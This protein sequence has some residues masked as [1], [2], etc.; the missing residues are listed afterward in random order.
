MAHVISRRRALAGLSVAATLPLVG[1]VTSPRDADPGP[2]RHG[3]ASGDPDHHSVILWTRVSGV[4]STA[5]GRWEV[6]AGPGFTEIV[7]AGDFTTDGSRDYTVKVL[8][9]SLPAGSLLYYRFALDGLLSPTGRT[10]TNPIGAVAQLGLAVAACSNYPFGYFNAY[11]AIALDESIDLVLH[12]GDYLYEYGPDGYGGEVGAV[13]GRSHLPPHETVTLDDYRQ[14]HAQYKGDPQLQLMHAAHPLVA[15]WDD[16]EITNNAWKGGAENHQPGPEGD[17]DARRHNALQAYYEWM[18]VREPGRGGRREQYWRHLRFGDL[19]SL[20]TLE[21]RLTERDQQIDYLAGLQR[22]RSAEDVRR[23]L[24]EVLGAPGREML[25]AEGKRA[26]ADALAESVAADRPWRV[27]GNQVCMARTAAPALSDDQLAALGLDPE[28]EYYAQARLFQQ[29][30]G[31]GLPISVDP[32]DGYPWAREQFYRMAAD[33]GARDLLVL[34]GDTHAFWQ[35]QLFDARGAAMG[36]E[37]GT[38]G[39]TSPGPFDNL[40]EAA[41]AQVDAAIAAQN[42]E[43]LWMHSRARGYLRL[44]LQRDRARVHFMGV[45]TVTSPD[46][47]PYSVREVTILR[48]AGRLRYA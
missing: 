17:W 5:R 3:V 41:A 26:A 36:L 15:I 32:W 2:F 23:F 34:T 44:V 11:G 7:A 42:R 9:G 47:R 30:A 37:L 40:G 35:N 48:Q 13:L 6:A 8:A 1:C 4:S 21:T 43:V 10:R 45:D 31:L 25:S 33:S 19:A 24:V 46:F 27:I 29:L 18:P 22:L 38:S 16:H 28:S 14:R 12:L 20:I 39:I